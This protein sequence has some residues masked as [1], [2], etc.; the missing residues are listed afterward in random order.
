MTASGDHD[1][2][3]PPPPSEGRD[4]LYRLLVL[5]CVYGMA[6]AFAIAGSPAVGLITVT[7]QARIA[8]PAHAAALVS[9]AGSDWLR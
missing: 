1:T 7:D 9:W 6:V 5:G 3:P 4:L 8:P 2:L